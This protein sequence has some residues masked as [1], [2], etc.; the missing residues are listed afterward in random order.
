MPRGSMVRI[1]WVDSGQSIAANMAPAAAAA[2]IAILK[3]RADLDLGSC[4]GMPGRRIA[5][6]LLPAFIRDA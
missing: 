1:G 6:C 5:A 3:L 4:L 2:T